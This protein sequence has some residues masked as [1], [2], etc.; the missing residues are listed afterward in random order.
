MMDDTMRVLA[1]ALLA[2]LSN[3]F[4][5][6]SEDLAVTIDARPIAGSCSVASTAT[7]VAFDASSTRIVTYR[8][9]RS[10][11]TT[12]RS[13]RVALHG[14]GAV[15]QSVRDTWNP[16]GASP[17]VALEVI[18]PEHVRSSRLAVTRRCGA[19]ALAAN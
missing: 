9:V 17:W 6:V 4:H 8:F 5:Q 16:H 1:V 13:G 11:G 19:G 2:T 3:D 10:D 14:D 12:S 7:I 18:A 15:A